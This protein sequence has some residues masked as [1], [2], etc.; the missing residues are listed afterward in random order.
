MA[1]SSNRFLPFLALAALIAAVCAVPTN[2]ERPRKP[3]MLV[4]PWFVVDRNSNLNCDKLKAEDP[5]ASAAGFRVAEAGQAAL[6]AQMHRYGKL[7]LIKRSEWEPYW[8]QTSHKELFFQGQGCAVCSP[9]GE[10]IR[11][12]PTEL[13]KL[14]DKVGAE[15]VLLG[16]TVVPLTTHK[17]SRTDECCRDALALERESV[18]ARSSV[19]L[20]RAKDGASIWQRD[21]RRLEKEVRHVNPRERFSDPQGTSPEPFTEEKRLRVAVGDTAEALGR[22]FRREAPLS[23]R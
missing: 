22:A 5:A 7:D 6:D 13:S 10:L 4:L 21:A 8:K 15:F 16:L 12:N 20:I 17:A 14:A 9:V 3:R 18:L 23:S 1:R 19:I 2:A 11:Y